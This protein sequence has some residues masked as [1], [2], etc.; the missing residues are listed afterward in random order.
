MTVERQRYQQRKRKVHEG[1]DEIAPFHSKKL[2]ARQSARSGSSTAGSSK[3]FLA[4]V[5][6]DLYSSSIYVSL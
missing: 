6:T 5:D 4:P 1:I 2:K 3:D